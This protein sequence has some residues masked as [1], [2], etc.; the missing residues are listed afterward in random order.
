MHPVGKYTV[1]LK[2]R[3]AGGVTLGALTG[4]KLP[5]YLRDCI[6]LSGP[7]PRDSTEVLMFVASA[8][9]TQ[10]VLVKQNRLRGDG[11]TISREMAVR[12]VDNEKWAPLCMLTYALSRG[13]GGSAK[14]KR[15]VL[16]GVSIYDGSFKASMHT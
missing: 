16:V 9:V 7:P 14:V 15:R 5:A 11:V 3:A 6:Q 10:L 12:V 13:S 1:F 4:Y 8:D 2:G